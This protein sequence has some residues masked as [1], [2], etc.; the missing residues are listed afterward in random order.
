MKS[1]NEIKKSFDNRKATFA[2]VDHLVTLGHRR[3]GLICGRSEVN[4]RAL[5]LVER[6]HWCQ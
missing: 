4:D 1:I 3:I 6:T 2:A 5:A